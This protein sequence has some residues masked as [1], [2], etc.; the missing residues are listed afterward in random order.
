MV[1]TSADQAAKSP[2]APGRTVQL[3]RFTVLP[4]SELTDHRV[5]SRSEVAER[6]SDAR[7]PL[8]HCLALRS[9]RAQRAIRL[10]SA[11]GPRDALAV[12]DR[13]AA[14]NS[15]AVREGTAKRRATPSGTCRNAPGLPSTCATGQSP[16]Q[17]TSEI[18]VRQLRASRLPFYAFESVSMRLCVALTARPNNPLRARVLA[19]SAEGEG[20]EPSPGLAPRNGSRD[21]LIWCC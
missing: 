9:D 21:R 10:E 15:I 8:L 12:A 18:V 17:P 20:F 7:D 2:F 5:K 6:V 19:V 16:E 4:P 1:F 3:A 11:P 14:R 13:R